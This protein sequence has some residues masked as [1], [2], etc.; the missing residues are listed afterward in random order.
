M[1]EIGVGLGREVGLV[2]S[3]QR[4]LDVETAVLGM[5]AEDSRRRGLA[6]RVL[7]E[8]ILDRGDA[9]IGREQALDIAA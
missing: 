9:F 7:E 8:G 5:Q 2:E 4:C 1:R 3:Q 6:K